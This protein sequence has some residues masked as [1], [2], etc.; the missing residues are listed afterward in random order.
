MDCGRAL[1][2]VKHGMVVM[3][4]PDRQ[5]LVDLLGFASQPDVIAWIQA[6]VVTARPTSR[7]PFKFAL[8]CQ[9]KGFVLDDYFF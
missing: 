1:P 3:R 7:D 8:E 2:L 6:E 4:D 9:R 5:R